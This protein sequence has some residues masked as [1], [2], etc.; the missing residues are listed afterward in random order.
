VLLL[1]ETGSGKTRA[2]RALHELSA[3]SA[4][5]LVEVQ[6]AALPATLLEAELFGH[7]QGA[8][9][10][11]HRAREGRF[12][13]ARGGTIVLDGVEC[14]PLESQVKLLRVLQEREVE[15]LG[16]EHPVA[17]DARVVATSR[18]DLAGEAAAGRFR[19]DLFW[20]LAVVTLRLPP[21]RVRLDELPSLCA[22][23]SA[24]SAQRLGLPAR[25]VSDEALA[26][27]RAHPWPGNV[28]ELEN[29]L[30]RVLVLAA[31]ETGPVAAAELE[32][33]G[34]ATAGAVDR[35]AVEALAHGVGLAELERALLDAA[36]REA[37]GNLS[38]AARRL[39]ITRR[40]FEYRLGRAV[41]VADETS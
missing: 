40:S 37:H 20:R 33:L 22:E 9:T 28:R 32:F 7:E 17:V 39:G 19:E 21:L 41:D 3:R 15:P 24:R 29:A 25:A 14:L 5:P 35:M 31:G 11:A 1:G 36:L 12:V 4:G 8:F 16:S 30:E 34:E 27:L 26:R 2:A 10:G 18:L 23:L 6:L 38:A 13:R